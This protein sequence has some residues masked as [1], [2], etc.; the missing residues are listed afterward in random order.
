MFDT[1]KYLI[2][3]AG[4]S[5]FGSKSTA[6]EVTDSVPDLRSVT[7]II[8]GATSGI[9]YETARV[10]AM[11]GARLILPA[12]NIKAAEDTRSRICSEFPGS[13]VLVF[14][15]EL[16]SLGSVS[17]FAARFLD[18][19]LPL[20][21]LINNAGKF[22]HQHG[23]SED[24]VEM[25]F[26][27]N[28][29]GHFLLTELLLERM[30]ETA[31]ATGMQARIVNVSSGIHG[32][33]SGNWT[34]YLDLI[35]RNKI[36]YDPTQAYALSKLAN[37]LYTKEL[38]QRLKQM[39]ADVTV[40]CVHPGIV[41]TRLTR[42]REGLLTDLAFF[43]LSKFLKTIPQAAATT[44]YVATSPGL[45]GVSGKYFADCNEAS[46]SPL[47]SDPREAS[48]LRSFSESVTARFVRETTH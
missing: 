17:A 3:S 9:G 23:V 46:P 45:A 34:N 42:E 5:G 31:K 41:R 21:L 7:A 4:A 30:V 35:T 25:T 40:N 1:V 6:E 32:W 38:A 28:Y 10:L 12:R 14:P 47:A 13:E 36:P 8:T 33:F 44:C 15:L 48:R 20:H 22:S 2:G 19:D 27:T 26:A 39:Q 11:R 16:S 43:F 18:L 24:G 37:V 29:L